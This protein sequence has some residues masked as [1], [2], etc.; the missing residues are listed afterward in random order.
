M[1]FRKAVVYSG[2]GVLLVTLGFIGCKSSTGP[3]DGG[4]GGDG[5]GTAGPGCWVTD[6]GGLTTVKVDLNDG[7]VLVNAAHFD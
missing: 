6:Q 4:D 1:D 7:S 3:D 5:G 2:L